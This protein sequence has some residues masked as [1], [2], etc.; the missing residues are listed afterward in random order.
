LIV[1][2]YTE[3]GP[4]VVMEAMARGLIIISTPVGIVN[5]HVKSG[6]NGWVFSSIDDVNLIMQEAMDYLV[7]LSQDLRAQKAMAEENM[8]YAF[9]NFGIQHF[10]ESYRRFFQLLKSTL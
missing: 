4:L 2:S 9:R 10:R 5:E 3:S 6:K 7:A 8:E 1:T